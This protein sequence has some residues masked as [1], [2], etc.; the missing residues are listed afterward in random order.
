MVP[1]LCLT[2]V[3]ILTHHISRDQLPLRHMYEY[4][5]RFFQP[6]CPHLAL[7][8]AKWANII[9]SPLDEEEISDSCACCTD[10]I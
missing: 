6:F 3:N 4:G 9:K 2:I 1:D 10:I 7:Q 5:F 8:L